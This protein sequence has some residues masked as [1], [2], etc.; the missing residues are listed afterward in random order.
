MVSTDARWRRCAT[1]SRIVAMVACMSAQ[2]DC[3]ML[4]W[5]SRV[6]ISASRLF[7]ASS[8]CPFDSSGPTRC[9]TPRRLFDMAHRVLRRFEPVALRRP[10]NRAGRSRAFPRPVRE[11]QVALYG[12]GSTVRPTVQKRCARRQAEQWPRGPSIIGGTT[13]QR[14]RAQACMSRFMGRDGEPAASAA[15]PHVRISSRPRG[16]HPTRMWFVRARS[17]CL[18][19]A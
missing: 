19:S 9:R 14:L 8:R 13:E 3:S 2:H 10:T 7:S 17:R 11:A 15:C 6:S 4:R 18:P 16:S 5:D 12:V 1:R